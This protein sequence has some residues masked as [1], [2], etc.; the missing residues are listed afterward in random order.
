MCVRFIKDMNISIFLLIFNQLNAL[1]LRAKM[2]LID[3][4]YH[5]M[6]LGFPFRFISNRKNCSS[7][8]E[9]CNPFEA[10]FPLENLVNV[11]ETCMN[12]LQ[13]KIDEKNFEDFACPEN[14]YYGTKNL[15]YSSHGLISD[16]SAGS[17]YCE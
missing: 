1:R 3:A 7:I 17:C 15:T 5:Q 16:F 4:C 2:I 10:G 12:V 6:A 8:F 9:Y 11:T 13:T 14:L